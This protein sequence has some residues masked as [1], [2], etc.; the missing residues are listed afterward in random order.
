MKLTPDDPRLSAYLLGELPPAEA[1]EVER[2]IA[3]DPALQLSFGD[4]KKV[5]SFLEG[6]LSTAPP[7]LRPAQR[8]AVLKAGRHADSQGKVVEFAS[9]RRSW[10]PWLATLGAAAAVVVA[11]TMASRVAGPGKRTASTHDAVSEVALLPLPGPRVSEG[12]A[13]VAAGGQD[14]T[15]ESLQA[16]RLSEDAGAFLD[17]VS[18]RLTR[19]PLPDPARLPALKPLPPLQSSVEIGLPVVIGQASYGWLRGWIRDRA[20]LPPQRAVRLEEMVNTF[21]L[22]AQP[23]ANVVSEIQTA[24]CPWNPRN[25]LVAATLVGRKDMPS[26]VSWSFEAADG[27]RVRM[28]ASAG[29]QSARLPN[30]L[31][32]GRSTTV[33]LEVEPSPGSSRLGVLKIDADGEFSGTIVEKP[34]G[35]ASPAM[36]QLGLVAAFGLWLGDAGVDAA[37]VET[38]LASSGSDEDPGRADTRHLVRQALDISAAGR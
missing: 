21:P 3:A 4:L 14:S 28:L 27:T 1:A 30:R 7:A 5:A 12:N 17:D 6:S 24:V 38:V 11:V 9:A 34:A 16:Q 10:R 15:V 25:V 36:R 37:G 23:A 31:P 19:D 26:T 2:A 8:E 22:P 33:L 35:A 18:R 32:A 20:E 13:A 29:S